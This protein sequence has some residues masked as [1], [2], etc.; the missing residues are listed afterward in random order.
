M[1]LSWEH[2]CK[3]CGKEFDSFS[4]SQALCYVCEVKKIQAA[5]PD[6]Q[7]EPARDLMYL[8]TLDVSTKDN[9]HLLEKAARQ[10]EGLVQA[11]KQAK[12]KFEESEHPFY[13]GCKILDDAL[14]KHGK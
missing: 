4:P 2:K 1:S 9:A 6:F 10:L 12:T 13:E 7:H 14:N 5:F 8:A 11:L 3:G